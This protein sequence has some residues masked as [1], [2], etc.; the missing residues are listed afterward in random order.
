MFQHYIMCAIVS[1]VL[2]TCLQGGEIPFPTALDS[3]AIRVQ[4]LDSILGYALLIDKGDTTSTKNG[5]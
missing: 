5:A 4:R 3:S 1:L 2:T